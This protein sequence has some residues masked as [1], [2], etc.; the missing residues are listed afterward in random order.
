MKE[1]VVRHDIVH[2]AGRTKSG[3]LVSV[4]AADVLRVRDE[5]RRFA[6]A[7]VAELERRFPRIVEPQEF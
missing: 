7:I 1:V 2:R 5:V 3:E 4:S 6:Q